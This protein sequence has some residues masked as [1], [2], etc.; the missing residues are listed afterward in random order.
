MHCMHRRMKGR[1]D[2]LSGFRANTWRVPIPF[3]QR[4]TRTFSQHEQGH[5]W[6]SQSW[7][8]QW[9]EAEGFPPSSG[10]RSGSHFGHFFSLLDPKVL[11]REIRQR[12][13][14]HLNW[15]RKLKPLNCNHTCVLWWYDLICRHQHA[16]KSMSDLKIKKM[17]VFTKV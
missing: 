9:W 10:I 6:K 1:H 3:S 8:S 14:K 16:K 15:K 2:Q 5:F 11:G 17:I 7:P 12:G 4:E 13:V